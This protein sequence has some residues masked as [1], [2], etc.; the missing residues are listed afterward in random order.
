MTVVPEETIS[1]GKVFSPR[2]LGIVTYT[3]SPYKSESREYRL[4][5]ISSLASIT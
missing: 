5:C 4:I 1:V 3:W 2:A